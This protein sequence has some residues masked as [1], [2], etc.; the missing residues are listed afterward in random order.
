VVMQSE[1][2]GQRSEVAL[3][4]LGE[5]RLPPVPAGSYR[6]TLELG[7]MAI[8]LPAVQIPHAA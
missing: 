1:G 4:E 2:D 5:F 8:E 3:N 7:G 6:L